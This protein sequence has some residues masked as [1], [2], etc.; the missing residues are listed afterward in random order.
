MCYVCTGSSKV[1]HIKQC[2]HIANTLKENKRFLSKREAADAIEKDGYGY[3]KDCSRVGRLLKKERKAVDEYSVK[4]HIRYHFDRSDGSLVMISR[5]G[6]WKVQFFGK[7]HV[8]FL[9]HM[10]TR[11]KEGGLIPG[12]H[13][14]GVH[15]PTLLEYFEYVVE[16]DKYR[17]KNPVDHKRGKS[18][19]KKRKSRRAQRVSA[20]RA[21]DKMSED[22]AL[23]LINDWER[24]REELA[25]VF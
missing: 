3:C 5:S 23:A 2:G 8:S 4:H 11:F 7:H 13:S 9:Y 16:H 24:E 1:L 21:R 22:Y 17:A 18:N 6:T 12:Y 25:G 14:Q 15:Y 10:N 19:P 20:R